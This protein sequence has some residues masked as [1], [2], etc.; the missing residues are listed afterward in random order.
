MLPEPIQVYTLS[1]NSGE[2]VEQRAR[3]TMKFL[4][5]EGALSNR[6]WRLIRPQVVWR[7][8]WEPKPLHTPPL[9]LLGFMV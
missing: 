2:R 3:F 1:G 8:Q 9:Q 6:Y 7:G 4:A 5:G